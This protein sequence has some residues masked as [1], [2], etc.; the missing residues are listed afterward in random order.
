VGGQ[1][2]TTFLYVIKEDGSGVRKVTPDPVKLLYDVS[3]DGKWVAVWA[4]RSA[5]VYPSGGGA[6]T[7]VC[8][9]CANRGPRDQP[10]LVTWSRDG[11]FVYLH[12]TGLRQ[13]YAVPVRDG[14]IQ[15]A[16][17]A[18][19]IPSPAAVATLPG[20]RMIAQP[21]AFG[22]P[23]PSVYAFAKVTTH[24]NIYRIPVP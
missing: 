15:S 21:R 19:G 4:G 1:D 20:V 16:L 24:R 9:A 7:I 18:S 6:P 11:R 22:G 14:Q 5:V 13:T 10:G 23:N 3:P 17:P 12:E 8:P 2:S